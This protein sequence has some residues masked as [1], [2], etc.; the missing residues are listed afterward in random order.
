ME[1]ATSASREWGGQSM[2]SIDKGKQPQAVD[3]AMPNEYAQS[4]LTTPA[5]T[6]PGIFAQLVPSDREP[7]TKQEPAPNAD[8]SANPSRAR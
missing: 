4:M 3:Q 1:I 5:A 6:P 2:P 8:S 7:I